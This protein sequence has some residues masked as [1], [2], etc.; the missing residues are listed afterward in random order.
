M[1]STRP[2]LEIILTLVGMAHSLNQDVRS[3]RDETHERLTALEKPAVKMDE[4]VL[5]TMRDILQRISALEEE[6]R[7]LKLT[8]I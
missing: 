5:V 3:M 8:R 6:I 1:K 2:W 4:P 7:I